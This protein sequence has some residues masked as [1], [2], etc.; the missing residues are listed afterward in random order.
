MF[1]FRIGQKKNENIE[2]SFFFRRACCLFTHSCLVPQKGLGKSKGEETEIGQNDSHPLRLPIPHF[3][4]FKGY[5]QTEEEKGTKCP[6][7]Q[8]KCNELFF[9]LQKRER[10]KDSLHFSCDIWNCRVQFSRV[11]CPHFQMD[12]SFSCAPFTRKRA[13]IF[14]IIFHLEIVLC[15]CFFLVDFHLVQEGYVFVMPYTKNTISHLS[16][17]IQSCCFLLT[18]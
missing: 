18:N 8:S 1:T 13:K 7:E 12:I 14:E 15:R 3:L 10:E 4:S 2:F 11:L 16:Y 5:D 17:C 6:A 9:H